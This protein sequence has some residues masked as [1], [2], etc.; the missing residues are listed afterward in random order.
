MINFSPLKENIIKH[1]A[2]YKYLTVS[3]MVSQLRLSKSIPS[4]RIELRELNRRFKFTGKVTNMSA[5]HSL[6]KQGITRQIRQEDLHYLTSKGARFLE[7]EFGYSLREIRYPKKQRLSISNDYFHRVSSISMH[8]SFNKWLEKMSYE[9]ID[10]LLY[11]DKRGKFK[12]IKESI[13]SRIKLESGKTKTPDLVFAFNKENGEQQAYILEVYNGARPKYVLEETKEMVNALQESTELSKRLGIKKTPRILITCDTSTR[14]EK[15]M[16]RIKQDNFFNYEVFNKMLFFN[17]D[18]TV[19][20]DF[21]KGWINLQGEVF[22][23]NE[24]GKKG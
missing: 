20:R 19:W 10:T 21:G 16:E 24:I 8:V 13:E 15:A 1:L 7:D 3:N 4:I 23:L 5:S 18:D 17:V 9:S 22:N 2:E 14:L 12:H 6:L 11:Y